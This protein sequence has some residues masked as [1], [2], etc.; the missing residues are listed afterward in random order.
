MGKRS[1]S[2]GEDRDWVGDQ[3][4]KAEVVNSEDDNGVEVGVEA[5]DVG[6][7]D[8]Y[9]LGYGDERSRLCL[10]CFCHIGR[11]IILV[12]SCC[13]LWF[14]SNSTDISNFRL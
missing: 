3:I 1:E 9:G 12:V 8:G 14:R 5:G 2:L 11:N 13:G 7:K 4:G 6:R 10:G